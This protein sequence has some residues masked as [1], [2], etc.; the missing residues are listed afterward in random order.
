MSLLVVG[1][2]ALDSVQTPFGN[3]NSVLGG[4]AS[5]FSLAANIFTDVNIVAV[6]GEDFPEKH[7]E[8]FKMKGINTKGLVIQEGETFRWEGKYGYDLGD[9]ET[10]ATHLNVF[11]KFDPD[12][13]EEYKY[14]DHVFLANIDPSIQLKVLDQVKSPKIVACDTMNFWIQNKLAELKEI[15]G[16][17]NILIINDSEARELASEPLI[18]NAARKIMDMGP[19]R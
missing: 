2:V 10:L 6:V 1:S 18:T 16:R 19:E 3:A 13:P 12:I 8:M 15:I 17:I 5:Y 7:L 11:E 4:S 9:P 14:I